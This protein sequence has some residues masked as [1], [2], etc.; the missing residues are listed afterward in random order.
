MAFSLVVV[1]VYHASPVL[2]LPDPRP[3]LWI[4]RPSAC[5][6]PHSA[7][8]NAAL[9]TNANA[10]TSPIFP[11]RHLLGIEGLSASDITALLDL[12]DTYV[13]Q[14]RQADKKGSALRGRTQINLF[15]SEEHTSE[16]QSLM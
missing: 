14:N 13:V 5:D 10:Q 16:L 9:M 2:P 3:I 1:S 6:L 4:M 12:A 8:Y 11:H 7:L 15:R